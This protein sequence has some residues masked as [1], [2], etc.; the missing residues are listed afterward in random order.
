MHL[1]FFS[2]PPPTLA[3]GHTAR[4]SLVDFWNTTTGFGRPLI[5]PHPILNSVR[6]G[7][8][9]ATLNRLQLSIHQNWW[10]LCQVNSHNM[11]GSVVIHEHG[12]TRERSSGVDVMQASSGTRGINSE[13][14]EQFRSSWQGPFPSWLWALGCPKVKFHRWK[15]SLRKVT[16]KT[17]WA[18]MRFCLL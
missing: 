5:K 1:W 15:T 17:W 14:T 9:A 10:G 18:E 12:G 7:L 13:L 3:D 16:I 2:F 4:N 8:L 6:E 11:P